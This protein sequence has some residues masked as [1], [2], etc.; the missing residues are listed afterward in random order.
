LKREKVAD[1]NS[2]TFC[3]DWGWQQFFQIL[4]NETKS[5]TSIVLLP[6]RSS[7]CVFALKIESHR[8]WRLVGRKHWFPLTFYHSVP[9]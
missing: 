3:H 9:V 5:S 1:A 4:I 6:L 2:L 7:V 8:Q